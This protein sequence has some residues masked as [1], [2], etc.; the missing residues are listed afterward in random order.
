MSDEDFKKYLEKSP[1]VIK[2]IKL[3]KSP[4]LQSYKFIKFVNTYEGLSEK[5]NLE[6]EILLKN[7][8]LFKRKNY[9]LL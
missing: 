9:F 5:T 3:N 6:R 8:P 1:K 4:L 2:N 7:N